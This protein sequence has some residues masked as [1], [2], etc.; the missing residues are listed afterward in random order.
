MSFFSI[1]FL[2]FLIIVFTVYYA[3]PGKL[4]VPWLLTA[5]LFFYGIWNIRYLPVLGAVI[6]ITYFT[7]R[8]LE[9]TRKKAYLTLGILSCLLMLVFFKYLGLWKESIELLTGRSGVS[10]G[11]E[12]LIAPVGISFYILEAIGYMADVYSGRTEC[13]KSPVRL[14]L[15]LSFFPKVISGPIERS[16]G[17]LRE[18]G[19]EIS[20]EY[21]NVRKGL[22]SVAA[23]YV[24]KLFIADRSGMIVDGIFDNYGAESG[25]ALLIAAILYGIQLYADFAGYSY[26]AVGTAEMF[27]FKLSPNFNQP[28]L[29]DGIG[30]FWSRWH[31]SLSSWLRDYIYIPLGG[32]RHGR[33]RK[34]L[35]LLVTFTVS[36]LWHGNGLNFIV[37]GLLHGIYQIAS[38]LWQKSG[39]SEALRPKATRHM[40]AVRCIK[41]VI[42]FA[43]VDFAWIFFRAPSLETGFSIVKRIASDLHLVHFTSAGLSTVGFSPW[44]IMM[45]SAGIMLLLVCD[46]IKECGVDIR[47][48]I[49][50]RRAVIRWFVYVI[51]AGFILFC[52]LRNY[53]E[54]AS[55]FIY[56]T[57]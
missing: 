25:T 50:K 33:A 5:S 47:I 19:Q 41:A 24:L 39:I 29:A 1:R 57:F 56:A 13:E 38:D 54:A 18:L 32:N 31:I 7:A 23:G 15:F 9:H 46:I 21:E 40:P 11:A 10:S 53:G 6:L 48:W 26:I 30:E 45:L 44:D 4:R 16:S 36:G 52:A 2:I 17:L 34:Y 20:F 37:W 27:G 22:I 12:A 55:S 51:T 43:L 35:N 14:A 49:T 8:K 28:Y 3:V 42:T